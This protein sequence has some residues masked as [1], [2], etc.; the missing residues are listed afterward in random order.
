MELSWE[1]LTNTW[2]VLPEVAI[3]TAVLP[4][5]GA[6]LVTHSLPCPNT[7]ILP[8]GPAIYPRKLK[9][10]FYIFETDIK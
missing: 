8:A 1:Y 7:G 9:F 5:S 3:D 2:L 6:G 4:M 10:E